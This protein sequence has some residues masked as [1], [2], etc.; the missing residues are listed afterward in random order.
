MD[1][2]LSQKKK[3]E[4]LLW[5]AKASE[6][7]QIEAIHQQRVLL[8]ELRKERQGKKAISD[9]ESWNALLFVCRRMQL[10]DESL[11]KK[12]QLTESDG[13]QLFA[14]RIKKFKAVRPHGKTS[15]KFQE[16]REKYY[17]KVQTLRKKQGMGW[18]NCARF[19]LQ[20]HQFKVSPIYLREV[21]LELEQAG[22][23]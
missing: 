21:V 10:S 23:V 2:G 19:L 9:E 15:A 12:T 5:L 11:S 13:D 3:H 1:A 20:F 17:Q 22:V 8:T 7:E 16:I 14:R 4:A 18:R 6:A